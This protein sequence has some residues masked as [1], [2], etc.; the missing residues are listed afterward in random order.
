MAK[1]SPKVK[2]TGTKPEGTTLC[3]KIPK[4][5]TSEVLGSKIAFNHRS[6]AVI[7]TDVQVVVEPGFKMCFSLTPELSNRGMV[8]TNAPGNFKTG[9]VFAH[10]M[11]VGREI[12]EI[13]TGDPLMNVWLE[14]DINF[15]WEGQ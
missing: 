9:T 15:S 6:S 4:T 3:A 10:V 1:K 14:E 5:S 2:I 8:A 7:E 12:V 13:K 11:N